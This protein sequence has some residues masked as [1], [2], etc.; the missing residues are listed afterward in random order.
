[1]H[2]WSLTRQGPW[3]TNIHMGK[4][5]FVYTNIGFRPEQHRFLKHLAVEEGTDMAGLVRDAVDALIDKKA[6]TRRGKKDPIW[7]LGR[8]WSAKAER[9]YR[10]EDWS[11]VDRDLYGGDRPA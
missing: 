5:R 3:Y 1:M 8:S 7:T 6:R 4:T 11:E 2:K 10:A 9:P